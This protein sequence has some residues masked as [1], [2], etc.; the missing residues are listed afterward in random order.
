M[1][2]ELNLFYKLVRATEPYL[3][4]A[5]ERFMTRQI[6]NHLH[7]SPQSV[8][9]EDVASLVDWLAISIAHLSDDSKLVMQY[10]RELDH[11]ARNL[12]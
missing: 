12:G 11:I 10:K 8:T 4:P 7:K 6:E 2:D 9:R 1:A 3:G 5:A